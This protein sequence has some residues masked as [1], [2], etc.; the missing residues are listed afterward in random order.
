MTSFTDPSGI[1]WRRVPGGV[2]RFAGAGFL[3]EYYERVTDLR[4]RDADQD[5]YSAF[6]AIGAEME[7][8]GK[9]IWKRTYGPTPTTF[10]RARFQTHQNDDGE[11]VTGCRTVSV[12]PPADPS[13][14]FAR[15]FGAQAAVAS[16]SSSSARPLSP[17]RGPAMPRR[18]RVFAPARSD[19]DVAFDLAQAEEDSANLTRRIPVGPPAATSSSASAPA[20][21]GFSVVPRPAITFETTGLDYARMTA[22]MPRPRFRLPGGPHAYT[23][24]PSAISR[25]EGLNIQ[26]AIGK[27]HLVANSQGAFERAIRAIVTGTSDDMPERRPYDVRVIFESRPLFEGGTK[28]MSGLP[29]I[30][31]ANIDSMRGFVKNLLDKINADTSGHYQAFIEEVADR[32]GV[33]DADVRDWASEPVTIAGLLTNNIIVYLVEPRAPLGAPARRAMPGSVMVR[34]RLPQNALLPPIPANT[35]EGFGE[36]FDFGNGDGYGGCEKNGQKGMPPKV[37]TLAKFPH[38]EAYN[39]PS[40]QNN[41]GLECLRLINKN[42]PSCAEIRKAIGVPN[43]V[44][45]SIAQMHLIPPIYGMQK[46]GIFTEEDEEYALLR[47]LRYGFHCL[48]LR[49]GHYVL[50]SAKERELK[51]CENCGR[52]YKK[53]HK[54][55]NESRVHY[56]RTQIKGE[57][58]KKVDRQ[59][60]PAFFDLETRLEAEKSIYTPMCESGELNEALDKVVYTQVATLCCL[61]FVGDDAEEVKK[62]WLGLDCLEKFIDYLAELDSQGISLN[63][64]AHNGSRFDA[65][66]LL[67]AIKQSPKHKMAAL[68]RNCLFKG[69]RLLKMEVFSHVVRDSL[70]FLGKSLAALCADFEVEEGKQKF[71]EINGNKWRTMDICLLEPRWSPQQY[72]DFL[73]S[74]PGA[75][76]KEAY[77]S[78]CEMDCKALSLVWKKFTK[79]FNELTADILKGETSPLETA[80]TLPGASMHLFKKVHKKTE[81]SEGYWTPKPP[82][83]EEGFGKE[84]RKVPSAEKLARAEVY[85]ILNEGIVGGISH[86]ALPGRH[87]A[88]NNDEKVAVVDVVSLYVWAMLTQQYPK[89]AP[90]VSYDERECWASIS[91]GKLGIFAVCDVILKPNQSISSFPSS[92]KGKRDWTASS[93]ES[94]VMTSVDIKRVLTVPGQSLKINKGLIWAETYN[95]FAGVLHSITEMKKLQD[96]YKSAKDPRYNQA[97][98]ECCKLLGNSLFGKMMQRCENFNWDEFADMDSLVSS[99]KEGEF[100]YQQNVRECNGRLYIRHEDAQKQL[101][102]L[103]FGVFIL[104]YSRDHMQFYFDVIG[105]DNVIATETD[106]IYC[107]ASALYELKKSTH[108]LY[109]I[110]KEIGQMDLEEENI[111]DSYFLGKK[112]YALRYKTKDGKVKEK[113]RLKG[114]PAKFLR[115]E[116][117]EQLYADCNVTFPLVNPETKQPYEIQD[118]EG[119]SDDASM[120]LWSRI[121]YNGA[122]TGVQMRKICKTVKTTMGLHE[123]DYSRIGWTLSRAGTHF[124]PKNPRLAV[125]DIAPRFIS[126]EDFYAKRPKVTDTREVDITL[127]QL[128]AR[129]YPEIQDELFT[130][131]IPP[132]PPSNID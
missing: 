53:T 56:H 87:F 21:P 66:I 123:Y 26:R 52:K 104:A 12:G 89:G 18:G 94:C 40:Q 108:P 19:L 57:A 113:F 78:Y 65:L 97:I 46:L 83:D 7:R 36:N 37:V 80:S 10:A 120:I 31:A 118:K 85:N 124:V 107:R 81:E 63:L 101:A 41:C 45:L 49:R 129:N 16:S 98:R 47:A 5:D 60:V 117:Y 62:S 59:L 8:E 125:R 91:A 73:N 2:I 86:V 75:P 99:L 100:L 32:I 77:I 88:S 76:F 72:V 61:Y 28:S 3:R 95:P 13:D 17:L 24:T 4:S 90:Q 50:V 102:P 25:E 23:L 42:L 11:T 64:M 55:E 35:W 126:E 110:G 119:F 30:S 1:E 96:V 68:A 39:P 114:I 115:W 93:I 29:L 105:R 103:Q 20:M 15:Q 51:K 109:S 38:L 121:S 130:S 58:R 122:R 22:G 112:C 111:F 69:T 9:A 48:L 79:T 131:F 84:K 70:C 43:G 116:A 67:G 27:F 127:G 132:P 92:V 54:C 33:P 82:V 34:A 74:E 14:P 6:L 71:A 106:S 44:P 128:A